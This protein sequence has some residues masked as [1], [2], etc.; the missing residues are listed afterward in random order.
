MG[1]DP[2]DA[3]GHAFASL[4][5]AYSTYDNWVIAGEDSYVATDTIAGRVEREYTEDTTLVL[6]VNKK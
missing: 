6:T 3:W 1:S 4:H 5:N 2:V